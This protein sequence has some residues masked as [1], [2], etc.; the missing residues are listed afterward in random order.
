VL[1]S[2]LAFNRKAG[3]SAK[4]DRLPEMFLKEKLPPWNKVV[5]ISEEELDTTLEF[6][7]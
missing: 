1:T 3:L 5:T 6:D 7:G 2:E 4:D